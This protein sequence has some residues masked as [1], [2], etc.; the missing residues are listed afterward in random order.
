VS[1]LLHRVGRVCAAM[2]AIIALSPRANAQTPPLVDIVG[3][4]E[5][6]YSYAT[7]NNDAGQVAG[8]RNGRP[9]LWDST[10]GMTDLG[11]LP[12][13]TFSE[14]RGINQSGQ[15]FGVAGA[16]RMWVWT[17][18]S[19]REPSSIGY[20]EI[21]VALNNA[22]RLVGYVQT[23]MGGRIAAVW[24]INTP[25]LQPIL[26]GNFGGDN[27]E[28]IAVNQS[29]Q[30]IGYAEVAPFVRHAFVWSER[31]GM[32]DLGTLGG[33]ASEAGGQNESGQVVGWAQTASGTYHAFLWDPVNGMQDLGSL[34][35]DTYALS[36]NE[37]GQIVGGQQTFDFRNH[38]FVW[39]AAHGIRD[40]TPD[41]QSAGAIRITNG[42]VVIGYT[43]P[44]M[45]AR[46]HAFVWTESLGLHELDL[47]GGDS[48]GGA[49]SQSGFVVGTARGPDGYQHAFV[50]DSIS[51][52][53]DLGTLGGLFSMAV[54]VNEH[55]QIAG[56]S[57]LPGEAATHPFVVTVTPVN[58]LQGPPGPPGPTGPPGP[59]G[60]QG[61]QGAVGPMGPAGP[62]G[63]QGPQGAQ[64]LQGPQGPQGPQG[65]AGPV[66]PAGPQGPMGP[67]G[68]VP[69]GATILL[70]ITLPAP[71]GY[72]LIGTTT[73]VITPSSGGPAPA[74][75]KFNVYRKN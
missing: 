41:A 46:Q 20:G 43:S 39:D 53:R 1:D 66:G 60:A 61:P 68:N 34:A 18:G 25:D 71:D 31:L 67:A 72:T 63:P 57:T 3:S 42:G 5:G 36:I 32:V 64:G 47:G 14:P 27:S 55:G 73:I 40:L 38:A 9:F 58:P 22:G 74:A 2:V 45:F 69:S 70:A 48:D 4:G 37:S 24:D 8:V 30:V 17:N 51:G 6:G 28:A 11:V 19:L 7:V 35:L 50:W 52:L 26:L 29:G 75:V 33:A 23:A 12:G 49:A 59:Q 54:T 56:Q 21:A 13:S 16:F 10:N 15:A 44:T 65:A 62:Q